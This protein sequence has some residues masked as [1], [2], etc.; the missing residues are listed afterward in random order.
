MA[1]GFHR[2]YRPKNISGSAL[3]DG[4]FADALIEQ[5]NEP[6][7]FLDVGRCVGVPLC[8][9]PFLGHNRERKRLLPC[10][11]CRFFLGG[12]LLRAGIDVVGEQFLGFVTLAPGFSQGNCGVRAETERLSL[13]P[14]TVVHAPEFIPIYID[15]QLRFNYLK[16]NI[17]IRKDCPMK[18]NKRA[19]HRSILGVISGVM[20]LHK[21][22]HHASE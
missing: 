20:N 4:H 15:V 1:C 8:G 18:S 14:K 21:E 12:F 7:F 11:C 10:G 13:P 17:K 5:G 2:P 9:E 6:L 16:N 3:G 22:H 19:I